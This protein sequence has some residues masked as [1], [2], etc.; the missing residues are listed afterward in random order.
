MFKNDRVTCVAPWHNI[1]IDGL[2]VR[3]CDGTKEIKHTENILEWWQNGSHIVNVR[4]NIQ[5][6]VP[7]SGCNRCYDADNKNQTSFRTRKNFQSA[8]YEGNYFHHSLMQSPARPIM[9]KTHLNE[10]PKNI[11]VAF[12]NLCNSRCRMCN[13]EV[14]HLIAIDQGSKNPLIQLNSHQIDQIHELIDKNDNLFYVEIT[15]GEPF[16][17]QE[18]L[19]FLN[20][21]VSNQQQH[22]RVNIHTNGTIWNQELIDV[23]SNFSN[24]WLAISI[25]TMHESNNYIRLGSD[26]DQVRQIIANFRS[27]LP[28]AKEIYLHCTPQALSV[29]YIDTLF[30]YCIK[31][32][33]NLIGNPLYFPRHLD[34]D[35]VTPNLKKELAQMLKQKYKIDPPSMDINADAVNNYEKYTSQDI[36][37]SVIE[38]CRKTIQCLEHPEPHDIVERRR[39]F[40]HALKHWNLIDNKYFSRLLCTIT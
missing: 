1:R 35:V 37:G 3:Y 22:V 40:H 9:Q 20:R 14:S 38:V 19:Q 28:R 2:G 32:K 18:V 24:L 16:L 34:I 26:I 13:E 23:L 8:I 31:H 27:L 12:S 29:M 21:M 30:D 39:L 4:K 6:G 5:Q 10:L 7:V 33:I 25:E 15:G 17:Q 36:P 11:T